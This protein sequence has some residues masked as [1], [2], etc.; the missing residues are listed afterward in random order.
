MLFRSGV[1][2]QLGIVRKQQKKYEEAAVAFQRSADADPGND[3]V[4]EDLV[5][6]W[7]LAGRPDNAKQAVKELTRIDPER[8]KRL[9]AHLAALTP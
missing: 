4:W 6:S 9:A 8:G 7:L 3:E 5:A 1:L 2:F